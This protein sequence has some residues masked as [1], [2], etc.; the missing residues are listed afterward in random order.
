[1]M[2]RTALH[3]LVPVVAAA[4]LLAIGGCVAAPAGG[5]SNPGFDNRPPWLQS[6]APGGDGQH[7]TGRGGGGHR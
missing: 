2:S 6:G 3:R 4:A 7:G 5:Y 1:M